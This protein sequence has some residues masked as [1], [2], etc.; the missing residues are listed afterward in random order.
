MRESVRTSAFLAGAALLVFAAVRFEPERATARILDDQ[1]QEFYPQFQDAAAVRTIEV[2]EYDEATATARPFQIEQ[3][4][5]RWILP[6]H[7]DFPVEAGDR[8]QK[9]SA[10]LIGLKK[11]QTATD[12]VA[13]H[14]RFGVVDPM[15]QRAAGLTGRGKRVTLRNERKE[16]LADFI[17][18]KPLEGKPGFRYARVP[19][20]KR[21]Y[22]V[23]TDADPSARFSDWMNSAVVRIPVAQMRRIVVNSYS[24]DESAGMLR[25]LESLNLVRENDAWKVP[26]GEITNLP[27]VQRM[28]A[29]LENLRIVDVKPKPP[30]LA[31]ALRSAQWELTLEATL[32]L[33]QRGFF[34]S[35]TG[36]LLS[37]EGEMSVETVNGL[38]YTLRFGEVATTPGETKPSGDRFLLLNVLFDEKRAARYGGDAAAGE[39]L[40][41]DLTNRFADW[42]YVISGAEFQQLRLKRK[43]VAR[44]GAPPERR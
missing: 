12:S 41:K 30:Q 3:R 7:H 11:D 43:D 31:N 9:T 34:L 24:I 5:G 15:D 26:S 28:A 6:S 16:V 14:S 38:V 19:G 8:L 29:T 1:G 4:K 37:N 27:A 20:Q 25:D 40:A 21:V 22:A 44:G 42:Y 18:G 17:L 32:S 2:I 39:R 36:R 23:K 35:P 33:R 10:A 13:E